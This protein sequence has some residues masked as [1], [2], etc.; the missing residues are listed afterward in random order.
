MFP[1][2]FGRQLRRAVSSAKDGG[3]SS[4]R[5]RVDARQ[6]T[7]A[8]LNQLVRHVD[9][10]EVQLVG[11]GLGPANGSGIERYPLIVEAKAELLSVFSF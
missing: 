11:N 5:R 1:V 7:E 2:H 6:L 10:D 8:A 3:A 9:T 4:D